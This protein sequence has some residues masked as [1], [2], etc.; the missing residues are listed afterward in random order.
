MQDQTQ[1]VT[2]VNP[3]QG[4]TENYFK[5]EI[6]NNI[7]PSELVGN[8]GVVFDPRAVALDA[9][10]DSKARQAL[11]GT[12][13][14]LPPAGSSG[15]ITAESSPLPGYQEINAHVDPDSIQVSEQPGPDQASPERSPE[16]VR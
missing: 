15:S 10:R 11:N 4:A 8:D 2:W 9:F 16:L 6:I 1:K 12:K 14:Y 13:P 5:R 3:E 7:P